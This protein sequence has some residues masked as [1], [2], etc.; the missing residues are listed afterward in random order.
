M[1]AVACRHC[2]RVMLAE[3]YD[4]PTRA[5]RNTHMQENLCEVLRT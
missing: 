2:I 5:E 4:L 1:P 3:R